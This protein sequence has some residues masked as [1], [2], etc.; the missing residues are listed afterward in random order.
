MP[1]TKAENQI[2]EL[3]NGYWDALMRNNAGAATQLTGEQCIVVGGR[4]RSDD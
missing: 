4:R 1:R 3:E 2:L